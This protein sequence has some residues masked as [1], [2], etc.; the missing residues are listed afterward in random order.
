MRP[1][2][3]VIALTLALLAAACGDDDV[4]KI[5]TESAGTT[6]ELGVDETLEIRLRASPTTGYEWVVLDPGVV[7]MISQSHR[8]DSDLDGS[9][10]YT[11]LTFSPTGT[12]LADLTLGYMRP[13][14]DDV[15]PIETFTV[16][17]SITG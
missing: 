13:W 3:A 8:P 10:G 11:T 17:V 12:G 6:V 5:D 9:P 7:E 14:E 15:E 16:T 2:T 1:H 4:V